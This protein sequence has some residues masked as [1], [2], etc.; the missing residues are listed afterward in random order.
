M[1]NNPHLQ[2]LIA[3]YGDS[4]GRVAF[5]RLRV[6]MRRYAARLSQPTGGAVERLS[7]RDAILITYGD[8]VQSQ[9]RPP[10]RVL[11]DFCNHHLAG[12]VSGIHILP[13]YPW[14]SD[15]GFSVKNYRTVDP[16][17]GDWKEVARLNRHF[18]LMVDAV[19]NHVS[20]KHA[21]FRGFLRGD[22][23]FQNRFIVV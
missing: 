6:M 5:D 11:A 9:P 21:W 17:L 23:R 10:L 7:Q 19:I 18:R 3:L 8:Q 22:P 13:F 20:A 4:A 12:L 14:T 16:A 2:H 15:D 1:T